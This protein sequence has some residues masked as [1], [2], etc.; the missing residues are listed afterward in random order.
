MKKLMTEW[1]QFLNEEE[2]QPLTVGQ[3]K[4]VVEVMSSNED[5]NKKKEKLKKLGGVAFKL[6]A[7]LSGISIIEAGVSLVDNLLGLFRGAT[8]P[9]I[10]NQ[11]KLDNEPWAALLG[12]D[13]AF[14]K[15]IDDKVEKEFLDKYIKRYTSDLLRLSDDTPLPNFTTAMAKHINKTELKPTP[16]PMRI[17]KT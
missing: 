5:Q 14:S 17:T 9:E 7:S 3:L 16:S 6:A 11:G 12:I 13:P 4:A 10:I 8:D 15:I 1:R 2:Q